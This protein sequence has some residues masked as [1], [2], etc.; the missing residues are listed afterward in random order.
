MHGESRMINKMYDI[1]C[2]REMIG[3]A[4][5]E[6]KWLS[7]EEAREANRTRNNLLQS[8]TGNHQKHFHENK[9]STG[10]LS[11]GCI[12]CG[13]G[14]W[15]C[16]F[17]GSQ[18]TA[19]CF[20]C[21]Q[22]RKDTRDLPPTE[23]GI[24]FDNPEDY[25]DYLKKFKFRGIGFS[26][27]EP[28]LK[29]KEL[30]TYIQK[31]RERLGSE[32][33]IW[34]YTNGDLVDRQKLLALKNA[35]MNELRFDIS[36]RNYDLKKIS[37]AA[38]IIDTVT[39]EIPAIPE[40]YEKV[41]KCLYRLQK[42]G[43]AHL[44]LHQLHSSPNCYKQFVARGYTF[45]HQ[46]DISI[47]ES[48]MT[49]LRLVK[50]ALRHQIR[51]PINYCSLIYK[52]RLQK[53]G[54][55]HRL[56]SFVR[57]SCEDLTE[58][59]FIRRMVIQDSLPNIRK[60]VSVFKTR[61]CREGLWHVDKKSRSLSFHPSLLKHIDFE[62]QGLI[63]NYF[64]PQLSAQYEANSEAGKAVSL[65]KNRKVYVAKK[66]A[67]QMKIENPLTIRC[68]AR[69]YIQGHAREVVF[70]KFIQEYPLKTKDDI[71]RMLNEKDFLDYLRIWELIGS[72]LCDLY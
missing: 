15:S 53:T 24:S 9:I 43:V 33:Y 2:A 62:K 68:F 37:L 72:G 48:E 12:S 51:L 36:S 57:E 26:G 22:D 59:G 32:I 67:Y 31:I 28:L 41:K 70:K 8:I 25:V 47:L 56:Q 71:P 35:G 19:N 64:V 29:F 45:L 21:P 16:I 50:Y 20:Y 58:S 44:N 63:L 3:W 60:T 13:Q 38:R 17:I 34:V 55:R 10:P 49:A 69:L 23:S 5:D 1:Q 6:M 14:T 66:L 52:H 30:I 39:V 65:N 61:K 46:P 27:G 7:N 40:D 4:Y 11:P 18:C 54:Y 42:I